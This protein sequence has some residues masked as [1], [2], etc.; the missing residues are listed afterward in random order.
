MGLGD[1]DRDI[2]VY[3]GGGLATPEPNEGNPFTNT[4]G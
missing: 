1:V 3:P 2:Y 4:R